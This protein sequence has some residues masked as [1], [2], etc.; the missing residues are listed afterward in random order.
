V[1][2]LETAAASRD[3]LS[4]SGIKAFLVRLSPGDNHR[5][6]EVVE[7]LRTLFDPDQEQA[8]VDAPKQLRTRT[9]IYRVANLRFIETTAVD[10]TRVE[11][12]N[13]RTS[14]QRKKGDTSRITLTRL[15]G[16]EY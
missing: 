9:P 6:P 3:R 1:L 10:E 4:P 2:P 15:P 5:R 12:I 11:R 13:E 8:M 14:P 16:G 7:E